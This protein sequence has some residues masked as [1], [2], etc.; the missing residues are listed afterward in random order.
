V[1][2]ALARFRTWFVRS[3]YQYRLTILL[4][5]AAVGIPIAG[6][7]V[8]GPVAG[9]VLALLMAGAAV[10]TIGPGTIATAVQTALFMR[11]S[12]RPIGDMLVDIHIAPGDNSDGCGPT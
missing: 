5:I 6:W 2:L 8:G 12:R 10:S 11:L 1:N 3:P 9:I 7:I 4:G